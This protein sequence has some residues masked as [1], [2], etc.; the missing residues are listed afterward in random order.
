MARWKVLLPVAV[1]AA[2][3]LLSGHTVA[4]HA[5]A[6]RYVAARLG[7]AVRWNHVPRPLSVDPA[8]AAL[9]ATEPVSVYVATGRGRVLWY[10]FGPSSAA[11]ACRLEAA[12]RI[13]LAEATE[14]ARRSVT[15]FLAPPP[16]R[17]VVEA[18]TEAAGGPLDPSPS[19]YR[20]MT[21]IERPSTFVFSLYEVDLTGTGRLIRIAAAEQQGKGRAH[22]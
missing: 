21:R 15:M 7:G 18:V 8:L 20:A 1:L 4:S 11:L 22:P 10:S 12:H 17:V 13:G 6:R 19:G 9:S 5:A 3:V 2:A 14:V 16:A